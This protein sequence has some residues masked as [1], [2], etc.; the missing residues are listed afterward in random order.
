MKSFIGKLLHLSIVD[1][2][3]SFI[4]SSLGHF[5]RSLNSNRTSS[6]IHTL[7]SI[8]CA[9]YTVR[10]VIP[11]ASFLVDWKKKKKCNSVHN[12]NK[13]SITYLTVFLESKT[14]NSERNWLIRCSGV[15]YGRSNNL[16]QSVGKFKQMINQRSQLVRKHGK[17]LRWRV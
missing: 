17:K 9:Q 10:R 2:V 1:L 11:T 14:S 13:L 16:Q 3:G 5:F 6:P 8:L 12:L 4:N 7:W 15:S